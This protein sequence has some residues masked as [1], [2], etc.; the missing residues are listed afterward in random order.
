MLPRI[1]RH[2]RYQLHTLPVLGN[3]SNLLFYFAGTFTLYVDPLYARPTKCEGDETG[4]AKHAPLVCHR[5][6]VPTIP[7]TW[8][9]VLWARLLQQQHAAACTLICAQST[10]CNIFG[11][12]VTVL[13]LFSISLDKTHG[14]GA[15]ICLTVRT[16]DFWT[17]ECL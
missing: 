2:T 13:F 1:L 7:T 17:G 14:R 6:L 16:F 5:I 12:T 4:M 8:Y 15:Q 11:T 3:T 10:T 9:F